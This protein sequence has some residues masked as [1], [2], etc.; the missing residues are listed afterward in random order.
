M[1]A[2]RRQR[3]LVLSVV[4]TVLVGVVLFMLPQISWARNIREYKDTLSASAPYRQSNHTLSF[5]IDT[6]IPPEGYID[7]V[8][9]AGF[10]IP[11]STTFSSVRNVDLSVDGTL[12]AVGASLSTTHD[13]VT[14][15]PGSPG[16]IRYQLNTVSGIPAGSR[17]E[18][19][20]GNH[21]PLAEVGY[22]SFSTTTGTTTVPADTPI[23]TNGPDAGTHAVDVRI[24]D[25]T[26]T[27]LANAGFVVA[28]VEE[29]G[30]GPVDTTEEIPPERFNGQPTGELSGT[31]ISVEIS[32]ETNE[33]A[34]C[35]YSLT[36]STTYDA[37]PGIFSSTGLL[38]H[39]RV[40]TVTPSSINRYYVRCMDD[41]GN[42]NVDDYLIQFS[43]NAAPT[44][45]VNT[46]GSNNGYRLRFG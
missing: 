38:F 40:V 2:I 28:L 37:M 42:K 33:F 20:I 19:R 34:V 35:K 13:L 1:F 3:V 12:R 21:T 22:S 45:E 24:Y 25:A 41:E 11:A 15:T 29:V 44:G 26:A 30:V 8:P 43:V 16:S 27:E 14:I 7:I 6:A 9:P 4:L 46:E 18:L 10:Y 36:A 17:L 31:T 5:L 39:S 32:L 23:I